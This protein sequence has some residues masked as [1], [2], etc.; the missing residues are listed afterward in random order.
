MTTVTTSTDW[1]NVFTSRRRNSANAATI[2]SLPN[3]SPTRDTFSS[4]SKTCVFRV[5]AFAG[6][7]DSRSA[8]S[9]SRLSRCPADME[10][11]CVPSP[12]RIDASMGSLRSFTMLASS[13]GGRCGSGQIP[14]CG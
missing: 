4:A 10:A 6:A 12:R 11:V 2:A 3:W 5:A 8:V 9:L 14:M 1:F 13:L 7:V